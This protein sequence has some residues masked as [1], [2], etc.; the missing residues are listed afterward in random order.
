MP[1]EP[2]DKSDTISDEKM[3]WIFPGEKRAS[4]DTIVKKEIPLPGR[5][6]KSQGMGSET[7]E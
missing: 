1:R 7:R 3:A 6:G 5:C 2:I 4:S